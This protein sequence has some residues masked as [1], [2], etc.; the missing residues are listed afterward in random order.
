MRV[1]FGIALVS[2]MVIG[3]GYSETLSSDDDPVATALKKIQEFPRKVT[4]E[5]SN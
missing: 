5:L 4:S 2:L 1:T 3:A